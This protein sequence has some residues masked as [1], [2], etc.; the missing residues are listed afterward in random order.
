MPAVDPAEVLFAHHGEHARV[1]P[2]HD[3]EP[4]CDEPLDR[5]RAPLA[6]GGKGL[7]QG[8]RLGVIQRVASEI[9]GQYRGSLRVRA[10]RDRIDDAGAGPVDPPI[11]PASRRNGTIA[12]D[13]SV[14]R[15]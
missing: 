14:R 8:C 12:A 15:G 10:D 13:G 5:L 6:G 3:A 9:V 1:R 11:L 4:D 2:E 7:E